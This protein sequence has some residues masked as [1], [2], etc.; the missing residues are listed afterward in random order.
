MHIGLREG[1]TLLEFEA[2][3]ED[4]QETQPREV[5]EGEEQA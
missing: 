5:L 3:G 1:I 4:Q 2:V